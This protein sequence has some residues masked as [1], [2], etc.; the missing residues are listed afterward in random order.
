[1]RATY[2]CEKDYLSATM[3][4]EILFWV[5]DVVGIME[6]RWNGIRVIFGNFVQAT[7]Q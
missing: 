2:Q 4:V 5:L 6:F 7:V 1:M 3:K